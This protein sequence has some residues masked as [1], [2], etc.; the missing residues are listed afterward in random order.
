M[1][2]EIIGEI[3]EC[4]N[5]D[6]DIAL[7]MIEEIK[8]AGCDIVKFQILDMDEIASDDPEKEWFSRLEMGPE[9]IENLI[10]HARNCQIDIL[11]TPVS[12]KTAGWMYEA[13]CRTVKIASS[14]LQKEELLSYI[15]EHFHKV[16]VSTG[17]ASLNE[18]KQVVSR[19]DRVENIVILHCVSEYP[20]G[21]LLEQRGLVALREEDAHLNMITILKEEFPQCEIGYSD[22]TDGI[23]VPVIAAAMGVSVIEKHVTL[24][25]RTPIEH[26][27]KGLSY[28]GTD[29]ILSIEPEELLEMVSQIRRIEIIKGNKVWE[30]S[31]GEKVLSEFLRGRWKGRQ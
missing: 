3:G 14:F 10:A 16:Y 6:F 26:F 1:R 17:M 4:F 13:G 25:R 12:I 31:K 7:K 21:P 9:K 19:F 11:F 8:Q 5:G 2:T 30:R 28:M 29:H 23:L 15:N 18:V 27:Q 24:D 22:H 20:T